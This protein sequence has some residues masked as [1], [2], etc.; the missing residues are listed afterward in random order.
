MKKEICQDNVS[1]F[2]V[3]PSVKCVKKK[4]KVS[5]MKKPRD[6]IYCF[7]PKK[8]EFFLIWEKIGGRKALFI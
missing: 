1:K 3:F 8:H 4:K 5:Q 2:P 7:L 6:T